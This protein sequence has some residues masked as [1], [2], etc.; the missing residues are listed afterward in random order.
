MRNA[1]TMK[2]T[3]KPAKRSKID[4]RRFDA[5][6]E[7]ER[8]A[9]ALSDPDARPMTENDFA[10]MKRTPQVKIIRRALGLSQDDFAARY[11][12]PIG[13]LRDWEQGRAT[14]DQAARAYLKVIARNPEIVRK[15]LA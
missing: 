14:P 12:I 7:K 5:M 6:T 8:H 2:K 3:T 15:A 10:L 1:D 4:W 9:A 11:Q 13:T